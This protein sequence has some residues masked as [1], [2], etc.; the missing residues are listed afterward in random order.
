MGAIIKAALANLSLRK[1]ME[2]HAG[3]GLCNT[4]NASH[5]SAKKPSSWSACVMYLDCRKTGLLHWLIS[6]DRSATI[7]DTPTDVHPYSPPRLSRL[8]SLKVH[9]KEP[10]RN[11]RF[12]LGHSSN[13]VFTSVWSFMGRRKCFLS[14]IQGEHCVSH[15]DACQRTEQ[16]QD[17]YWQGC[18]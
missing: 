5:I 3:E 2:R 17:M 18:W 4:E 12:V 11:P 7:T 13:K 15:C 10:T 9:C 14:W 16:I 1:C 6:E 8:K